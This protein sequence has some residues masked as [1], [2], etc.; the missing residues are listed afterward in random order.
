MK[1]WIIRE[2]FPILRIFVFVSSLLLSVWYLLNLVCPHSPTATPV[3]QQIRTAIT[4]ES[5]PTK[6]NLM[7]EIYGRKWS[8]N[9]ADMYLSSAD[10]TIGN[11]VNITT[12]TFMTGVIEEFFFKIQSTPMQISCSRII[13]VLLISSGVITSGFQHQITFRIEWIIRK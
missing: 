12:V 10:C 2:T 5:P 1:R 4:T 13:R 9:P 3:N 8:E 7:E 6:Y 11:S